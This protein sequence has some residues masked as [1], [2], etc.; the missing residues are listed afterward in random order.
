MS[1]PAL[2]KTGCLFFA[3]NV[4]ET[5]L[6]TSALLHVAVFFVVRWGHMT[7]FGQRTKARRDLCQWGARAAKRMC[8]LPILPCLVALEAADSL[9]AREEC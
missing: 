1:K 4:A 7:S 3:V 8:L 5:V 9:A 2:K 6:I